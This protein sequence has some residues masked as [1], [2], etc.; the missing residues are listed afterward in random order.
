MSRLFPLLMVLGLAAC[1][2]VPATP[3][4]PS[5]CAISEASYE[6]QVERYHNVSTP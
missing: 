3:R 2:A 5:P 6:C 4:P 1:T